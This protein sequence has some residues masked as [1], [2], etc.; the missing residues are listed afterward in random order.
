MYLS[1]LYISLSSS[2]DRRSI[3]QN[4]LLSVIF[5]R[6]IHQLEQCSSKLFKNIIHKIFYLICINKFIFSLIKIIKK[7]A[8]VIKKGYKIKKITSIRLAHKNEI[9]IFI[10]KNI[11]FLKSVPIFKIF[12]IFLYKASIFISSV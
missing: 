1:I 6:S 8:F 4:H 7:N 11:I 5:L 12:I 2:H 3:S 9:C 10:R